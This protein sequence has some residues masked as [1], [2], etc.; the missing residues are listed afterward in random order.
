MTAGP[1]TPLTTMPSLL[2]ALTL[3]RRALW[4]VCRQAGNDPF[5]QEG[6]LGHAALHAVIAA[7]TA[8]R[9]EMQP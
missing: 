2:D 3:A 8:A 4:E 7:Q 9:G 1:A 6:G 5:W